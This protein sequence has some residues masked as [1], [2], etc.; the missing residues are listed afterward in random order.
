MIYSGDTP[1]WSATLD[2]VGDSVWLLACF[3][4][5]LFLLFGVGFLLLLFFVIVVVSFFLTYLLSLFYLCVYVCFLFVKSV[6]VFFIYIF[7]VFTTE[8][9]FAVW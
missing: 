9:A 6:H 4:S 7:A 3:P 8:Y 1:F 5:R 2:M